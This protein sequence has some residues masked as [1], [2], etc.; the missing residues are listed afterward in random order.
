MTSHIWCKGVPT[1]LG[2]SILD[3][4][5]VTS[6]TT[7]PFFLTC[8]NVSMFLH[9]RLLM[10]PLSAIL[11]GVGSRVRVDEEVGGQG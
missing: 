8:V 6:F 9:V 3:Q 7:D 11:A 5:R 2:E 10:K 1:F 4:I